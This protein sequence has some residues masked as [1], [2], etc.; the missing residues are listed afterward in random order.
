MAGPEPSK[1]VAALSQPSGVLVPISAKQ[2]RR[3]GVDPDTQLRVTRY[4]LEEDSGKI[5]L[6][7]APAD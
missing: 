2:L 5:I 7:F 6:K 1:T 3:I 4:V